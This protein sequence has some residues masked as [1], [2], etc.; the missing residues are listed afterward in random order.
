MTRP[1]R[2]DRPTPSGA[3][4]TAA[5][6]RRAIALVLLVFVLIFTSLRVVRY[7]QKSATWDEP[8]HLTAGYVALVDHDFRVDPTHPPFMREWAALPL[9]LVPPMKAD[10]T[11]IDQTAV[12]GWFSRGYDFARRFLYVDNDADHLLYLARF[13]VVLCGCVLGVL[14]FAWA[15]EWLGFTAATLALAFFTFEPNLAAHSALV[16]TDFG[17]ACFIFGAV[18]FLWR[19]SRRFT[20]ANLAGLAAFVALA[21]ITKF[22]VVL[23]VPIF[24]PLFAIAAVKRTALTPRRLATTAAVLAAA[25]ITAVWAA[26]GFRYLPSATPGWVITMNDIA[27]TDN[28]PVLTAV[29]GWIDRYHLV[30]NAYAM[31]FL[32]SQASVQQLP[33]FMAGTI[34]VGGWWYY[35]PVAFLIKTPLALLL[36]F[37]AGLVVLILRRATLGAVTGLFLIVP[38]SVYL[39]AAMASGINLGVR[40]ILPIYPFVL[41]IA[42]AG[43]QDLLRRRRAVAR[44]AVVVCALFWLGEFAHTYPHTLTFFNL[45]V[46]GP[47]NGFKYLADSNLAWGGNLKLMKQWMDGQGISQINLAYFGSADPS[48]YH[49][50]ATFLPGS[51]TFLQPQITRPRLPGYVA[52]SGTVLDGVYLPEWWRI[53]YRGFHQRTPVA[54]IGNTMR[55]YWVDQWPASP[56]LPRDNAE[57]LSVLADGLML[58]LDWPELAVAP[59]REYLRRVPRDAGAWTRLAS[60]LARTGRVAEATESLKRVVELTPH[61]ANAQHNL[62]QFE[63]LALLSSPRH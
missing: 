63:R 41:L 40:H 45:L 48:Y 35:F 25:T 1:R 20:P 60:A 18:Y 39:L 44:T 51:A 34:K 19:L 61:D 36:L 33:A 24:L 5:P 49:V 46:G 52:I 42:T 47:A 14:L 2:H 6:P 57:A 38:A 8:M 13:M 43:V 9:R 16:T 10:T 22:S 53:F 54:V 27:G 37:A 4:A 30:P 32:S 17:M 56:L 58:G 50:K 23:L 3:G 55:V 7:R 29:I 28:V 11:E 15:Y 26:Y 21:A 12:R 59:Y 62:A 31:G